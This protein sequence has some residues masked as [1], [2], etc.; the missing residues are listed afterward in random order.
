MSEKSLNQCEQQKEEQGMYPF[1]SSQHLFVLLDSLSASHRFAKVFNMNNEQRNLL[2]TAGFKGQVK[3]NLIQQEVQSLATSLRILFRM[4][5]DELRTDAHQEI[6][7]RLIELC[8]SALEYFLSLP[9]NSH[10]DTWTNL[11]LLCLTKVIKLPE[12]RFKVHTSHYY[13]FLCEMV[14]LELKAELKAVL[15]KY[16]IKIG[17]AFGI[18]P[19]VSTPQL[20]SGSPSFTSFGTHLQHN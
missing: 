17:P 20:T 18:C 4:Y 13:P 10:R 15:R 3:P 11:L 2:W 1:L 6:E 12:E 14:C 9:S 19:T 8:K 7:R 5:L 16:F